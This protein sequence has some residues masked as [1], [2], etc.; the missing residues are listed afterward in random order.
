MTFN[1]SA[2]PY[3]L[4]VDRGCHTWLAWS[5]HDTK[6]G[7][8]GPD[9]VGS[10]ASATHWESF[11][12]KE[13]KLTAM[14]TAM[15]L[16]PQRRSPCV[17]YTWQYYILGVKSPSTTK[18]QMADLR[19]VWYSCFKLCSLPDNIFLNRLSLETLLR[20]WK[21]ECETF[22]CDECMSFQQFC[23]FHLPIRKSPQHD[24][25]ASNFI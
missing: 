17:P 11:M 9:S 25:V 6:P 21:I 14:V 18:K 23:S 15:V 4:C 2:S 5:H 16:S 19:R 22:N 12:G 24:A 7:W 20:S 1:P 10:T 13:K 3:S 8:V